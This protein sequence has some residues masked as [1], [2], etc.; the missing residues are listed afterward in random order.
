MMQIKK[1]RK[2]KHKLQKKIE[3]DIR[4]NTANRLQEAQAKVDVRKD[5]IKRTQKKEQFIMQKQTEQAK[6][7]NSKVKKIKKM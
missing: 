3:S 4:N 2:K 1:L 5:R 7:V 6:K